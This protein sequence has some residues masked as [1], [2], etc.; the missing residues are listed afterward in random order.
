MY[1]AALAALIVFTLTVFVPAASSAAENAPT[2]KIP[3]LRSEVTIDGDLTEVCYR[4][5]PLFEEFKIASDPKN[6]PPRT[7]AWVFWRND[8][9]VL[10]FEC[11]DAMIVAEPKTDNEMD[12]AGQD[13][14]E[15]FL[16]NGKPEDAYVCFELSPRGA[17]LD[18]SARFY[19]QID[20]AWDATGLRMAG[21]ITEDGYRVEA[22]LP[23]E[24]IAPFGITLAEGASFRAGLF[25]GN[26]QK[27][28]HSDD[29]F[30]WITWVEAKLP[31]PDFH[32]AESFGRFVLVGP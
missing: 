17:V 11:D 30:M 16:W 4:Q 18:Y 6:K 25:R 29:D 28:A 3:P 21:V 15:L 1:R 19:R 5:M 13:R 20:T 9:L 23:A 22:E 24:A 31:K 7:R 32:V 10:A 27:A 12:V 26:T 8:K 2:L 14:V